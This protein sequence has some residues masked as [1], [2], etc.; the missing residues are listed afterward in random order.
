MI[1]WMVGVSFF[2]LGACAFGIWCDWQAFKRR[3]IRIARL[4]SYKVGEECKWTR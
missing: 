3:R 4:M 1:A 2:V